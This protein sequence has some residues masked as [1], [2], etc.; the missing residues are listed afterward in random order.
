MSDRAG[1]IDD[2]V[3]TLDIHVGARLPSE[4]LEGSLPPVGEDLLRGAGSVEAPEEALRALPLAEALTQGLEAG[5]LGCSLSARGSYRK[6]L[7][8]DGATLRDEL[9]S[10]EEE[11]AGRRAYIF[12]VCVLPAL[13]RRGIASKIIREAHEV[14]AQ[15]GVEVMCAC[16]AALRLWLRRIPRRGALPAFQACSVPAAGRRLG[17]R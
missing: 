16:P 15:M 4:V 9:A 14:A 5:E 6:A 13:R 10:E 17:D 11:L 1:S 12:N 2:V 3:G 7:S 8:A